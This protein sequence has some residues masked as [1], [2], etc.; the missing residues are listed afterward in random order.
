MAPGL[1]LASGN[2]M[3]AIPQH[4]HGD[5]TSCDGIAGKMGRQAK[6]GQASGHPSFQRILL[7]A[8]IWHAAAC[9]RGTQCVHQKFGPG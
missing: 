1:R 5:A 9:K 2:K 4:G 3:H 6:A 7:P 8:Q